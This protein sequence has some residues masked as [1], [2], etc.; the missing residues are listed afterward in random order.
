MGHVKAPWSDEQVDKL[1]EWQAGMIK[2]NMLDGSMILMQTHPFTCGAV[3]CDRSAR[4]DEGKLIP[5]NNG[6]VCPC[7]DYKQDWCHDFMSGSQPEPAGKSLSKYT[8]DLAKRSEEHT[9][10]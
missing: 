9:S 3:T 7:G 4:E 5:S 2:I 10:E 8:I 1:N 6:W